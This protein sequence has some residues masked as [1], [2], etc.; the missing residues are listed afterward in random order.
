[1]QS[2][3]TGHDHLDLGAHRHV[4]NEHLVNIEPNDRPDN[5][6]DN[7]TA[8][9]KAGPCADLLGHGEYYEGGRGEMAMGLGAI[10]LAAIMDSVSRS[11]VDSILIPEHM[12]KVLDEQNSEISATWAI[13]YLRGMLEQKR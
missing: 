2:R 6:A 11:G 7:V 4:I 8:D 5:E 1:M 12:P 3:N 13:G 9:N 10:D